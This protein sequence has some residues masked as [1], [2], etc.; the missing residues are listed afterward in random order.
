MIT[1]QSD[2]SLRGVWSHTHSS[3]HT[4]RTQGMR[5]AARLE[6]NKFNKYCI[7]V[8]TSWLMIPKSN[9]QMLQERLLLFSLAQPDDTTV[10]RDIFLF[11]L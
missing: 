5:L 8:F 2:L 10:I 4:W 7:F 3:A 6:Y 11:A 9:E 1:L